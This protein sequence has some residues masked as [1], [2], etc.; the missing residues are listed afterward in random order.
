MV[1]REWESDVI[2]NWNYLFENDGLPKVTASHV[3]SI[4]GYI[5]ETVPDRVV[6]TTNPY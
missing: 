3:L 6:V 4:C 1:T 5:S 2:C